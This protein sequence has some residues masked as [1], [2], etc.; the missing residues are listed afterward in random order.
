MM[1]RR[2]LWAVGVSLPVIVGIM[3]VVCVTGVL[4]LF[5]G[6]CGAADVSESIA[7]ADELYRTRAQAGRAQECIALL[8]S[9]LASDPEN[10]DILWRLARAYEFV[11]VNAARQDKLAAFEKAKGYAERATKAN[12]NGVDGWYMYGLTIGRWGETRGILQSL[13]MA[14]PMR[15]ALLKALAIDPNHWQSLHVLGCLYRELPGVISFGNIN[16]AIEY[17]EQAIALNGGDVELRLDAAK[18]YVKKKDR[19][20][21]REHLTYLLALP[22]D[23]EDPA[24]DERAKEEAAELL[25]ALQGK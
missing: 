12:P 10:Y 20:K 14:A 19:V 9:C 11:G 21:A 8:E 1:G 18:A 17:F 23:P 3:G 16:K 22:N 6:A 25:K 13:S 15:D 5:R 24:A 4:A 2:N 7:S